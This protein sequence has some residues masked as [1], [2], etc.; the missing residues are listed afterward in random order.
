MANKNPVKQV[1]IPGDN[2][3]YDFQDNTLEAGTAIT[4]TTS[5]TEGSKNTRTIAA[6]FGTTSTTICKGNDSRLSN[7]RTPT[8][9]AD[10]LA[11]TYGG[12]TT[13]EYG[14]IHIKPGDIDDGS[15]YKIG[16]AAGRSHTHS[17]YQPK[18]NY[19]HHSIYLYSSTIGEIFIDW[20]TTKSTAYTVQSTFL[21]DLFNYVKTGTGT[22]GGTI[23]LKGSER[24]YIRTHGY[25]RKGNYRYEITSISGNTNT[26][27]STPGNKLMFYRTGY[28]G[29]V[30]FDID[31]Q[32][33]T[34]FSDIIIN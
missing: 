18:L 19:Y 2:T 32:S 28:K 12:G 14:H 8:S 4:I 31:S 26:G 7:T 34:D 15:T 11:S 23:G 16:I 13:T 3:V 6:S 25:V 33:F 10:L 21:S 22:E 24:S 9:H 20:W 27:T 5:T 29:Q 30:T 1:A 17:S